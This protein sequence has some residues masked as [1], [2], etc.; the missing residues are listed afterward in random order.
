MMSHSGRVLAVTQARE[1]FVKHCRDF[2]WLS[3][4][5]LKD[6]SHL[7]RIKNFWMGGLLKSSHSSWMWTILG[8]SATIRTRAITGIRAIVG[9]WA[10][11]GIRAI[12]GV[13]ATD[14][15]SLPPKSDSVVSVP[16][17]G[18]VASVAL[19]TT[20][21]SVLC[22]MTQRM[23]YVAPYVD[24]RSFLS[25]TGRWDYTTSVTDWGLHT[26]ILT[27]S[28]SVRLDWAPAS[29]EDGPLSLLARL[30][31]NADMAAFSIPTI[32]SSDF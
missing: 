14:I 3:R 19:S 13:W 18:S 26:T 5:Y 12:V 9:V 10:I 29:G 1:S 22:N 24:R 27:M 7:A 28:D 15:G 31:L 6:S 21:S 16:L 2:F 4:K 8:T 17:S 20:L 30:N 32:S 11:T 25:G 23:L